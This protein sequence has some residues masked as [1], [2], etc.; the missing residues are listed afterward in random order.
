MKNIR[1]IGGRLPQ[2]KVASAIPD[3][4]TEGV[5]QIYPGN[6]N[7]ASSFE[8]SHRDVIARNGSCT[9]S[10]A[11]MMFPTASHSLTR[12][13]TAIKYYF[14]QGD[15]GEYIDHP[16]YISSQQ[17]I[18]RV[19]KKIYFNICNLS[20]SNNVLDPLHRVAFYLGPW[21][22]QLGNGG[23]RMERRSQAKLL[24]V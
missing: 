20:E 14:R 12:F 18:Q 16:A 1:K 6:G 13:R 24:G 15:I 5:W 10:G 3:R 19:V 9:T 21:P 11:S 17:L 4:D 8:Y 7:V 23:G 22:G 2:T